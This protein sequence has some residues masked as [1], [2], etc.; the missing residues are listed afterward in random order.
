VAQLR[1]FFQQA[2]NGNRK[3]KSAGTAPQSDLMRIKIIGE[4][5]TARALRALLRKAGFAVSELL[6]SEVVTNS[7]LAG[8][9]ITVEEG[10]QSGWIHLDSVDSELEAAVF[11][12]VTQL[13]PHPV[14]VDRP[15]GEVHSERELRIVVPAGDAAQAQA[16]EYGELRALQ[17]L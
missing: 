6:P 14:S 17:E 2:I 3:A 5:D 8:Y 7:P 10:E 9:A 11:K 12:H 15:G 13:S 16:V 4:N 1:A